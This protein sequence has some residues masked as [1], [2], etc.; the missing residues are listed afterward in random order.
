M[1]MKY[2]F[3]PKNNLTIAMK[4]AVDILSSAWNTFTD[5]H[6]QHGLLVPEVVTEEEH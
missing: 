4:T 3:I 1:T 2:K 5:I 6:N